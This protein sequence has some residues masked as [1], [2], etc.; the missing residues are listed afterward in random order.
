[1]KIE[2]T[3]TRKQIM[4]FFVLVGFL[5]G[6]NIAAAHHGSGPLDFGHPIDEILGGLPECGPGEYL[7]HAIVRFECIEDRAS[8]SGGPTGTVT[9]LSE[10]TGIDLNPNTITS[11]G[12][13]RVNFNQVQERIVQDI[14]G[15]SCGVSEVVRGINIDGSVTCQATS[16]TTCL[17][18][19]VEYA[20]GEWCKT[21][22][23]IRSGGEEYIQCRADGAWGPSQQQNCGFSNCH[24]WCGS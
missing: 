5:G 2:V 14:L 23:I 18:N 6:I 22:N 17:W 3:L 16:G 10:G 1:M 21:E 24:P 19:G 4:G 12:I 11:T 20:T 15:R 8:A 7:T 13:V 9:A